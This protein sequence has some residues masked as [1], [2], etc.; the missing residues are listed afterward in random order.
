MLPGMIGH[1]YSHVS[2]LSGRFPHHFRA[3]GISGKEMGAKD[4]TKVRD[5]RTHVCASHSIVGG[6]PG[7]ALGRPTPP[8]YVLQRIAGR[9]H[10]IGLDV[11]F[12]FLFIF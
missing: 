7:H 6:V 2:T 8:V 11:A 9:E 10:C 3:V 5:G 4:A 1:G 12:F